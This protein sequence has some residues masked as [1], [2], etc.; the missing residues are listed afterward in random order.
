MTIEE[1][2]LDDVLTNWSAI[3][4]YVLR[5]GYQYTIKA[6]LQMTSHLKICQWV[7]SLNW[8]HNKIFMFVPCSLLLSPSFSRE[9][10][11]PFLFDFFFYLLKTKFKCL[12]YVYLFNKYSIMWNNSLA[13]IQFRE[14]A[15]SVNK[16]LL[17]MFI[18]IISNEFDLN[19]SNSIYILKT[20]RVSAINLCI[21]QYI[22]KNVFVFIYFLAFSGGWLKCILI[23]MKWCNGGCMYCMGC[24]RWWVMTEHISLNNEWMN[25]LKHFYKTMTIMFIAYAT[26]FN[27]VSAVVNCMWH[28]CL[29]LF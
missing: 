20:S 7:I 28:F 1:V 15:A 9:K 22:Y 29:N 6:L 17:C 14:R 26:I 3:I 19:Y 5:I 8:G 21:V 12:V 2:K 23:W 13:V 24:W 16:P 10:K 25:D 11:T 27:F 18:C 4:Y